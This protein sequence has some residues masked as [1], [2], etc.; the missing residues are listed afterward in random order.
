MIHGPCGVPMRNAP[1]MKN[2]VFS[3]SSPKL[4]ASHIERGW[5][6]HISLIWWFQL[7]TYTPCFNVLHMLFFRCVY[8]IFICDVLYFKHC[9]QDDSRTGKKTNYFLD[10]HLLVLYNRLLCTLFCC[11]LN[12]E[13]TNG[14][15]AMKYIYK[16][17]Y[18]GSN[19]VLVRL[20]WDGRT[21]GMEAPIDEVSEYRDA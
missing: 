19:A 21:V 6:P 9:G 7:M 1:C 3:K 5:A 14:I 10:N 20:S 11:H 2:R 4:F 17:V 13:I 8:I 18:K 12:L 15:A 16:Y